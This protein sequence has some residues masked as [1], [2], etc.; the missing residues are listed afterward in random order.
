MRERQLRTA[1]GSSTVRRGRE[2]PLL[3]PP[4]VRRQT[5]LAVQ[6]R[7]V[8]RPAHDHRG[9]ARH[10]AA[11]GRVLRRSHGQDVCGGDVR[12][13]AGVAAVADRGLADAAHLHGPADGAARGRRGGRQ[14]RRQRRSVLMPLL[15]GGFLIITS[16]GFACFV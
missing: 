1:V 5:R 8:L 10:L 3:L 14:G 15:Y 9:R 11:G 16:V 6:V 12:V 7:S 2:H 13:A 4:R